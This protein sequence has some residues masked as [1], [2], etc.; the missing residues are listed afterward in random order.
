MLMAQSTSQPSCRCSPPSRVVR[1]MEMMLLQSHSVPLR[2]RKVSLTLRASG[3]CSWLLETSSAPQ[4][5]MIASRPLMSSLMKILGSW[6]P[7]VF[8]SCS[9]PDPK[10]KV[11][12]Q[13]IH[14]INRYIHDLI[15][16]PIASCHFGSVLALFIVILALLPLPIMYNNI[17]YPYNVSYHL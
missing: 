15:I 11:Y 14:F 5:L 4:K 12:S 7:M 8:F 1:L 13:H 6:T 16:E 3:T 17:W 2:R 10:N 9:F